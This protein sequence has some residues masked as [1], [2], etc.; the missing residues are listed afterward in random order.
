[1]ALLS[2]LNAIIAQ[3]VGIRNAKTSAA[4]SGYVRF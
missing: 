2:L 3:I 4:T 1:M